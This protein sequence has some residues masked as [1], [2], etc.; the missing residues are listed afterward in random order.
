MAGG[1][2]CDAVSGGKRVCV[3]CAGELPPYIGAGPYRKRCVSCSPVNTLPVSSRKQPKPKTYYHRCCGSCGLEF[4][5]DNKHTVSCGRLCGMKIAHRSRSAR[6]AS[7][8]ARTCDHCGVSFREGMLSQKQRDAGH[9]QKF[10]SRK[11]LSA[12]ALARSN[13]VR[14]ERKAA[15][16]EAIARQL[17]PRECIACCSQ[18]AP[19]SARAEKCD[20]CRVVRVPKT[21]RP[22][23]GCGELV[24]GNA[25]TRRCKPC[26]RKAT[27]LAHKAKHGSTKKHRQRARRFGVEYEPVNP[28]EVFERDGWTCHICG[29]RTPKARRGSCRSNAPELDH[30]IAMSLGGSHTRGN[31]ACACRACNVAKGAAAFGQPSLL[32]TL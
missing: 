5:T 18:F 8:K 25:A 15:A 17:Q 9:R 3:S 2:V 31:L 1:I 14:E 12:S 30:I 23:E 6:V 4:K 13:A 26:A 24:T 19:R 10:C 21:T 16:K 7:E 27:R 28:I 22:C 20:P 29:K 32:A 11:C